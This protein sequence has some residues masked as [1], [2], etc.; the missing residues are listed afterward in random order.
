MARGSSST[1][2]D[3]ETGQTIVE[4]TDIP[5]EFVDEP[6]AQDSAPTDGDFI[7]YTGKASIR[8]VTRRQWEQAGVG[9]QAGVEWT[10]SNRH[11]VPV[12]QF[13]DAARER[14]LKETGFRLVSAAD[15]S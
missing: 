1:P 8:E 11:L 7:Q 12:D 13:T 5:T 6:Q 10:V 9:H 14:I 4:Q 3:T 15:L 2:G